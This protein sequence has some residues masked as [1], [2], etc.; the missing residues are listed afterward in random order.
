MSLLMSKQKHTQKIMVIHYL[1]L[2]M[3]VVAVS[4][5][6][7]FTF[8]FNQRIN[9]LAEESPRFSQLIISAVEGLN[10]PIPT[11]AKTGELYLHQTKLHLPA[12]TQELGDF[13]YSYFESSDQVTK[14]ELTIASEM[15]I[16]Q[17]SVR[18]S[19][20]LT[21]KSVLELVPELQACARGYKIYF[22]DIVEQG[23]P[24]V[25][26]KTLSDGRTVH[27]YKEEACK[28]NSDKILAYLQQIDS[29]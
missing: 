26:Q 8:I 24:K 17:A 10:K 16:R 9:T 29:Y 21:A 19:A 23:S 5:L 20:Q 14:S 22:E 15:L 27:I 6:S 4:I 13:V 18:V 25:L 12:P 28:N 1:M 7:Y 2:S 11:D 3:L